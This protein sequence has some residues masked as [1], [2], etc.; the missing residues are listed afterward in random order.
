MNGP[1]ET[2]QAGS[3]PLLSIVVPVYNEARHLGEV[4]EHMMQ[5]PCPIRREWIFV[6]DGSTDGSRQI[7]REMQERHGFHLIGHPRNQGKGSA[8]IRGLQEAR[9]DFIMIQDADFEYDPYDVP[10]LLEP[11][12]QG[13]ADVVFGNRFNPSVRQVHRTWHYVWNRLLTLL[14]NAFSGIRLADMGTC[15]KIFRADL[16]KAMKLKSRRYGIEVELT[17]YVAKTAARVYEL[18]VHYYP[19]AGLQEKTL[20]WKDGIAALFHLVRFNF[21][22]SPEDAFLGLPEFY[23]APHR[24]RSAQTMTQDAPKEKP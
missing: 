6:D 5:S 16:L 14:S 4:I 12:L 1:S 20:D 18:P 11:L 17:A 21:L 8:V 2:T 9:G 10:E 23:R 19:R 13:R 24:P 7:L 3:G 15:Y 22:I